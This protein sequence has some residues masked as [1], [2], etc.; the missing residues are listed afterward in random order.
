VKILSSKV[1]YL[2]LP[3]HILVFTL[4]L[5]RAVMKINLVDNI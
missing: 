2:I 1:P 4:K 3:T 5:S